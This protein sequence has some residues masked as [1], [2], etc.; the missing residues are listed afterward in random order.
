MI[1]VIIPAYNH[2]RFVREALDS[3]LSQDAEIEV[4]A[5]DDGSTD[6]TGGILD[7][8]ADGRT[9]RVVHQANAGAHAAMNRG[10]G[11]CSGEYV[12]I[13]NSDDRYLPGRLS[14]LV[15][16][17]EDRRSDFAFSAVRFVDDEGRELDHSDGYVEQLRQSIARTALAG[18]PL[19]ALLKTNIAIS[20]GNFVFRRSLLE[21]TGGMRPYRVCHDWD[22]LLSASYFTPLTFVREPLYDYRVHGSNTVSGLRFVAQIEQDLIFDRFFER[23]ESHP[24]L[25]HPEAR[26]RF[27]TAVRNLSFY[28]LLPPSLRSEG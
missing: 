9:L 25:A 11:L 8:L 28:F 3:V 12:A 22:F 18:N 27:L 13:L 2:A 7:A 17:M 15:A 5:V 26:R 16:A 1:S 24:V 20:S 10:F 19:P 21:K 6:G 14:K 23:I 4:I